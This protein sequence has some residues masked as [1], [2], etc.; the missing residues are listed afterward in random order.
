MDTRRPCQ[1]TP[2]NRMAQKVS[3]EN[4]ASTRATKI[5]FVVVVVDD[6]VDIDDVVVAML[7]C[8]INK[9]AI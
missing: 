4:M 1:S 9:L 6:A 3:V 7:G 5:R 8:L 2:H